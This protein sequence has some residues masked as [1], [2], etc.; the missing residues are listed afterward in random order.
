VKKIIKGSFFYKVFFFGSI[1]VVITL[2]CN[3]LSLLLLRNNV[4]N[5]RIAEQENYIESCA[6]YI[7]ESFQNISNIMTNIETSNVVA[8]MRLPDFNQQ[9]DYVNNLLSIKSLLVMFTATSEEI[10]DIILKPENSDSILS[11]DGTTNYMVY[12]NNRYTDYYDQWTDLF[13]SIYLRATLVKL[14]GLQKTGFPPA[15]VC[16]VKTN[17]YDGHKIGTTVAFLNQS[18]LESIFRDKAFAKDRLI[19]VYDKNKTLLTS[20]SV[21]TPEVLLQDFGVNTSRYIKGK[22][23]I[24]THVSKFNDMSYV[25]YTPDSVILGNI[26]AIS[27]LSTLVFV[28]VALALIIC[29]YIM[30]QRL[31]Q[32]FK[33]ILEILHE[34]KTDDV[35]ENGN[36]IECI[37]G[38]I[39]DIVSVNQ[40]LR[41]NLD[42]R[43]NLL[44]EAILFRL[45]VGNHGVDQYLTELNLFSEGIFAAFVIRIDLKSDSEELF[46]VKYFNSFQQLIRNT[47]HKWLLA[48]IETDNDEYVVVI[49]S[50]TS[51]I[52]PEIVAAMSGLNE[53]LADEIPDSRFYIGCG[54]CVGHVKQLRQSYQ[55]AVD[56]ILQHSVDDELAICRYDDLR[57]E[58][59]IFLPIDWESEFYNALQTKN[60]TFLEKY[61][62]E[63]LNRNYRNH[64]SIKN[65]IT[66]CVT[67]HN[68]LKRY[69]QKVSPQKFSM[70]IEMDNFSSNCSLNRLQDILNSN[71]SLFYDSKSIADKLGVMEKIV[72]YVESRFTTD[73]N[74]STAAH[75]LGYT[76]NYLSRYFKQ[77]KGINFTDFLNWRRVEFSKH[78]L[79]STKEAIKQIALHAGFNSST[80]YIRTFE[81]YVGITPGE[82]RMSGK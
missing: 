75:A 38:R 54:E 14:N 36:E 13:S 39:L 47:L 3:F 17:M 10:C 69:L 81:R 52:Y 73:I 64:L 61:M 15:S 78:L 21:E 79:S 1:L 41:S 48:L 42:N 2:L 33:S 26:Q 16:I 53:E 43:T 4:I 67:I 23:I 45:M 58:T 6:K 57:P 5:N 82:Y 49:Y 31:Y 37:T 77:E 65:Y 80:M 51:D 19:F 7:D 50:K 30:S 34:S 25:I 60:F 76:P 28:I 44:M 68:Y 74:L 27:L 24:S 12:Y 66:L 9:Q 40:S 46:F 29:T 32:P 18:Y 63:I 70:F 11:C 35:P 72:N 59:T 20:N 22:G 62:S 8:K 55:Q 71:L 56:A